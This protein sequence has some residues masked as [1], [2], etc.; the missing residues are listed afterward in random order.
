M[1]EGR[2]GIYLGIRVLD[3]LNWYPARTAMTPTLKHVRTLEFAGPLAWSCAEGSGGGE[4]ARSGGS[5][6]W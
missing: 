6:T 4:R 5:D 1:G 2:G 3:T